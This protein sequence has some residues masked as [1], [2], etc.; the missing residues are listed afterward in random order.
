MKCGW[1]DW[2]GTDYTDSLD[3]KSLE[4]LFGMQDKPKQEVAGAGFGASCWCD[5]MWC[6]VCCAAKK[7]PE[8]KTLLDGNRSRNIEIFLPR[9]PL[10][11]E[12]LESTL[13]DQLNN[14]NDSLELGSEH[15]VALKR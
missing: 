11:L 8:I 3:L 10:P 1:M 14:V 15:I 13:S 7:K 4:D 5:I 2:S 12:N 6:S 9:L